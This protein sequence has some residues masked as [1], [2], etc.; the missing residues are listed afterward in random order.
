MACVRAKHVSDDV[1]AILLFC[2]AVAASLSLQTAAA[3]ADDK[4]RDTSHLCHTAL[5]V[6]TCRSSSVA[7]HSLC[8]PSAVRLRQSSL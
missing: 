3:A 8:L 2:G 1:R 4:V 5:C 7:S 6:V